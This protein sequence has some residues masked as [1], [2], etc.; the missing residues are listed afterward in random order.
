MTLVYVLLAAKRIHI[1]TPMPE[2]K[3]YRGYCY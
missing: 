1:S 2:G 3:S